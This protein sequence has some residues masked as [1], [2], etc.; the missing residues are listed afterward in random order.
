[1]DYLKLFEILSQYKIGALLIDDNERILHYNDIAPVLLISAD[2]ASTG[3]DLEN[4]TDE[5]VEMG[6][7]KQLEGMSAE[8]V[9]VKHAFDLLH[10][11]L[12]DVAPKLSSK[13]IS[14]EY[15]NPS[16]KQYILQCTPPQ[17]ISTP[18]GT[19]VITFRDASAEVEF[20]M[21][22]K[23]VEQLKE[24]VTIWDANARMLYLNAAAIQSEGHAGE[25]VLGRNVNSLYKS[26]INEELIIPQVL[27]SGESSLNL[28]QDFTTHL[29]REIQTLSNNYPLY[30]KNQLLGAVSI[31][32]DWTSLDYLNRKIIELQTKLHGKRKSDTKEQGSF[33]AK[34]DFSNIIHSSKKMQDIIQKCKHF[35][36]SDASVIIYGETGTGKELFAQSIHNASSRANSP[37]VDIN[38]A[39]IPETLLES[40]LFGTE[41]G[42]YTG[43]VQ[44]SGLLEQANGGTLLLDELNSLNPALQSKL[45]RVIQE[46]HF[47]RVG[48]SKL[49]HVD[50]RFLSNM[51]IPPEEAVANEQL[52]SDL[53]YRLGV[54]NITIPPLRKRKEDIL[55]LAKNFIIGLNEKMSK[56]ILDIDENCKKLFLAYDWPGN[57][58]ELRHA[59]EFAMSIMPISS[60]YITSEYLPEHLIRNAE[61]LQMHDIR[62]LSHD[63]VTLDDVINS[64]AKDH[65]LKVLFENNGN[66]SKSAKVLGVSRQSLQYRIKSLG[67]KVDCRD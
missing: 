27:E 16:F 53:Y 45:L 62:V 13:E 41:K 2:N 32:E 63:P 33:Y 12:A 1:M 18:L 54:I 29:G 57:V 55:I 17:N 24:A 59:I 20:D 46:G 66:I 58:R 34:Y 39:A 67:I 44:S 4:I 23:V 48:G 9:S 40:I 49:I 38:C 11:K 25:S 7:F 15:A 60:D 10:M 50:V 52:R 61:N 30:N 64:A 37:F 3:S 14:T 31:M 51:N 47:R 22:K 26:N 36:I 28:R 8:V 65:V 5:S 19:K 42:A 43:A 21:L 56:S 6:A 35:A